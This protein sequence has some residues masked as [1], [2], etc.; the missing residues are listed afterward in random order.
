MQGAEIRVRGTVQGVGFRPFVWRLARELGLQGEVGNDGAGVL[1][2]AWGESAALDAL[3]ERLAREAPPLAR[4]ETIERHMLDAAATEAG[5]RIATSGSG[6]VQ[7]GI[8]AD[9]ASCPACLAEIQDTAE[10]RFRYPFTN[11][12]HCGP[13]LSIARAIPWDRANTSMDAF[14]MCPACRAEYEDPADRRFHAQPI[15]CPACGP[16]AWIVDATAREIDPASLGAPDAIAA[17]SKLLAAGRIVAIKGIGGFHLACDARNRDAVGELRRRKQRHAKPF[18]LMA[19]DTAVIARYARLGADEA[20]VL[21]SPA[22]PVVLL[23]ACDGHDLAP[24]VAPGQHTLGFLLPYTPLHRLLLTQW[25]TPLVMTSGNLS[26]EPQ[27]IA[28]GDA[29]ESLRGIADYWLLH[30]REIVNRL[31]DSVVRLADGAP[32]LLRRARGYAPAPLLLHR[33]FAGAPPLVALG[34]ELK[35]TVCLLHGARATVSQHLGDLENRATSDEFE[36]TVDLYLALY[37]LSPQLLV[38]DAHPDYRS[39]RFAERWSARSG[40]E[41]LCVQHHHAHLASVLAEHGRGPDAAPVLGVV[42]DGLGYGGDGTLWGGEFLLAD[43]RDFRRLGHLAPAPMPGGTQA[44]LE[45]W[46]SAWA[47]I[48]TTMGSATFLAR[49]GDL[50][51]A[52]WL[53]ARPLETLA[54]MLHRGINS[55]YSSSCGRLFDAVAATI[56]ICRDRIAYEGQAAIELEALAASAGAHSGGYDFARREAEGMQVLDP[57]PLWEQL[58]ADLGSGTARADVA[59]RFHCGLAAAV[60]RLAADLAAIHGTGTVALSGGV[61]QNRLLLEGVAGMLRSAGL[62]VLS[63]REVPSNDGGLSLGQAAVGAARRLG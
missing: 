1:I 28:N 56:G 6:A 62:A 43:F 8:A 25:D 41:L 32:R 42:L 21:A 54:A 45:P 49:Q 13:R 12:T 53:A 23:D 7:T 35:S 57:A 59:A 31:D 24:A 50:E 63:Q 38:A 15:A 61:F 55:P 52:R 60:A 40:I 3:C 22:A 44:I 18:A 58:F 33:D 2:R 30:E 47:Q 4:I 29:A 46:R 37:R 20:A 36:R 19:R 14:P 34:G 51:F 48:E 16:R 9:A 11:C 10:R 26:E 17:A 39:R 27:C 5:F